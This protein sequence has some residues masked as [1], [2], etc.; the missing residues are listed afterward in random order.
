ML[1]GCGKCRSRQP[2]QAP[3]RSI[4]GGGPDAKAPAPSPHHRFGLAVDALSNLAFKQACGA[5]T[6]RKRRRG[7]R[8]MGRRPRGGLHAP[9]CA[10]RHACVVSVYASGIRTDGHTPP[11]PPLRGGLRAAVCM[12]VGAGIN[13]AGAGG[14]VERVGAGQVCSWLAVAQSPPECRHLNRRGPAKPQPASDAPASRGR[15]GRAA[16]GL[17]RRRGVARGGLFLGDVDDQALGLERLNPRQDL[18]HHRRALGERRRRPARVG[19]GQRRGVALRRAPTDGIVS[20][21]RMP[22]ANSISAAG[23]LPRPIPPGK[24]KRC[25]DVSNRPQ[26]GRRK[27]SPSG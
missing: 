22:N 2:L 1:S 26:D 15:H 16:R 24:H 14:S 12:V 6:R 9:R 5:K 23:R 13:K 11:A 25:D 27:Q 17:V 21:L 8:G 19:G 7:R 20:G 3:A 18:A 4:C 10:A